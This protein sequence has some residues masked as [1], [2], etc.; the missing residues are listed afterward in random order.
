MDASDIQAMLARSGR[1]QSDLGRFLGISKDSV[2]RLVN[3][4]RK[5][6]AGEA[7]RL[8]GFF[9]PETGP[10]YDVLNVFGYAQAGGD[11]RVS[12]ASDHVIDRL[13]VPS[14]LVRG[15]AIAVRVAGDSMEPRLFS[16]ETL[17]IAIDRPPE[18]DRDCVVEFLDGTAI[19]KTY[20]G[21][22]DGW[23]HLMQYNPEKAVKVQASS[24]RAIHAVMYRR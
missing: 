24:V 18:R 16:G 12:L 6:E 8:K 1:S 21:T 19:V 10:R 3:G 7:E 11:D 20:K 15:R 13:E 5:L 9:E 4:R 23:V 2:Y 17:I 22:R 14:G